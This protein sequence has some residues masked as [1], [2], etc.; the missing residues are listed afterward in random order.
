M[1]TAKQLVDSIFE[2]SRQDYSTAA[3]HV[4]KTAKHV[5]KHYPKDAADLR[6]VAKHLH[7][8]R[9]NAARRKFQRMDT[10]AGDNV[11]RGMMGHKAGKGSVQRSLD[12]EFSR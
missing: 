3:K 12:I 6:Q 11:S 1:P 5:A 9:A 4:T 10:A 2:G 7:H 8:G